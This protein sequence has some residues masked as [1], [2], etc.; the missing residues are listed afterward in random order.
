ML[1]QKQIEYKKRL[2]ILAHTLKRYY[3]PFLDDDLRREWLYEQY[4]VRSFK[5]LSIG[6]LEE[7]VRFLK[8]GDGVKD[9][10]SQFITSKQLRAM[11]TI[12]RNNARS[13]N[14]KALKKWIEKITGVYY[15]N[16]E[17]M[18]KHQAIKVISAMIKMFKVEM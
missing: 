4:G 13:K 14:D 15:V 12:W 10:A 17:N 2:I 9:S 1:S 6:Q 11:R 18:E 3:R 5:D 16:L 7:V 8:T